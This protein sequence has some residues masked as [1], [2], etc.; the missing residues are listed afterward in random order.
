MAFCIPT[1]TAMKGLRDAARLFDIPQCNE[2]RNFRNRF[3]GFLKLADRVREKS[4]IPASWQDDG[5]SSGTD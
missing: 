4:V 3:Y 5:G 1:Q 2:A